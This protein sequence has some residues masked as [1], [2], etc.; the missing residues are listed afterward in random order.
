MMGSMWVVLQSRD[1]EILYV[2][3]ERQPRGIIGK[4]SVDK[5][6]IFTAR[7]NVTY[8]SLGKNFPPELELFRKS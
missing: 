2:G 5:L 4:E 3:E 6:G 7:F 1:S 8:T